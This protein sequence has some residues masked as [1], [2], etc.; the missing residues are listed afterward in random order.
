MI[1]PE[2]LELLRCPETQQPLALASQE[3]LASL[4]TERQ[5][6]RLKNRVG[7]LVTTPITAGLVRTDG[8][9]LYLITDG[10][11]VVLHD[12]AILL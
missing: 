7:Q 6:G 10:I 9:V 1:A 5:A 11:P 3:L 12:E 8:R 4:E 2:L